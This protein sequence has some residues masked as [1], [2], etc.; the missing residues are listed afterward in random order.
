ME[1]SLQYNEL[2]L[3][4]QFFPVSNLWEGDRNHQVVSS[5]QNQMALVKQVQGQL[6]VEERAM[7]A[8]WQVATELA[9]QQLI[10]DG[11]CW[12]SDVGGNLGAAVDPVVDVVAQVSSQIT[13][14]WQNVQR[15]SRERKKGGDFLQKETADKLWLLTGK[16]QKLLTG[17]NMSITKRKG[18]L[19][20]VLSLRANESHQ[21]LRCCYSWLMQ[22]H[23]TQYSK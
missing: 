2:F 23:G 4:F 11:A 18:S 6:K 3:K 21:F 19:S 1:A 17:T 15:D 7:A 20:L 5:F 22:S 16:K 13:A 14:V 10:R 9:E 8:C 12:C